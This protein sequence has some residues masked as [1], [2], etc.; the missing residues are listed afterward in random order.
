MFRNVDWAA[1]AGEVTMGALMPYVSAGKVPGLSNFKEANMVINGVAILADLVF[2]DKLRGAARGYLNGIGAGGV[3]LLTHEL[4]NRYAPGI[5]TSTATTAG[6]T[7]ANAA[8][9]YVNA[10]P[11]IGYG[12]A[13]TYEQD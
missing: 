5:A 11:S 12:P 9:A 10:A 6:T 2:A 4:V 7:G 1:G 3:T 8:M 13:V